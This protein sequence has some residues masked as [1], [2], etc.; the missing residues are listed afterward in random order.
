MSAPFSATL[1]A[2]LLV[3]R[4]ENRDRAEHAAH[5]VVGGRADALR[6]CRRAGHGGEPRHHLHDL[7]QRRPMLVGTG[8]EA[9]VSADDEMR[10][11]AAQFVGAEPLLFQ[12]PVAKIFQEHVGAGEQP[13]HGLAVFGPGEIE[14]DAALAAVE[15][16][17]E[18]RS[19]AAEAPGL[20][21]GGR[22]DLD[23]FGPKLRQDHAAGRAH[24]HVGHFDH[25]NTRQR[26]VLRAHGI[27]RG[28]RNFA[29][30]NKIGFRALSG[31]YKHGK[32]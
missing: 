22:F 11:F 21:A 4:G 2:A 29:S 7:V 30:T 8:Q 18:R 1:R 15:Q 9:L 24:H 27:S 5:D 3:E 25:P 10:I 28:S 16:R 32:Q 12:L 17:E 23:D 13:M 31:K 26:Q 20:V 6:F 19:H 14:H